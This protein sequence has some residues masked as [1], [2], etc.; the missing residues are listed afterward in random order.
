VE[1][2]LAGKP[3]FLCEVEEEGASRDWQLKSRPQD[4]AVAG[5]R[6]FDRL[7]ELQ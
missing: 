1:T 6:A 3:V 7:C 5:H 2:L 4:S